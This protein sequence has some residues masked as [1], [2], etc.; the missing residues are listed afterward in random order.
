[1]EKRNSRGKSEGSNSRVRRPASFV[2]IPET[3]PSA[4][5]ARSG[6][7]AGA[8][9][10]RQGW[11]CGCNIVWWPGEY[12]GPQARHQVGPPACAPPIALAQGSPRH[13]KRISVSAGISL[14]SEHIRG[15]MIFFARTRCVHSR[16]G[17]QRWK[18]RIPTS[19]RSVYPNRVICDFWL[20][21]GR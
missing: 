5:G 21:W 2:F 9:G 6:R 17:Y 3:W 10:V 8:W 18:C 20:R 14:I 16:L 4:A 7:G 11:G 1:M 15:W 19:W 12:G 13:Q